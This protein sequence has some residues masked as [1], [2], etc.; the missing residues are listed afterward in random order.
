MEAFP[1]MPRT[2]RKRRGFT[3]GQA[4][5]RVGVKPSEYRELVER[6]RPFERV[7]YAPRG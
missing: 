7:A 1:D 3:I 4:A 2:D 5:W 6:E